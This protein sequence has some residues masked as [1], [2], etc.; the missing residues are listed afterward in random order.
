MKNRLAKCFDIKDMGKL[1]HFLGMKVKQD[2][3]TGRVWIRQPGYTEKLLKR[4]G[5]DQAKP[6]RRHSCGLKQQAHESYGKG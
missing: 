4:F 3:S 2:E 6:M 5:M 1:H